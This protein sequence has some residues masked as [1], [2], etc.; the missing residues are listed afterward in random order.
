MRPAIGPRTR[1]RNCS[2]RQPLGRDQQDVNLIASDRGFDGVPLRPVLRMDGRRSHAHA[3]GRDDLVAHQRQQ[4]RDQQ[5][6]SQA[7]LPEQL[8]R[9]EIDRALAPARLLH[10]EQ[11]PT[12]L[13]HMADGVLL[14]LAKDGGCVLRAQPQEF[15]CAGR[16]VMHGT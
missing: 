9:D 11:S 5:R 15:E 8:G 6:R 16:A 4:G 7:L 13:H 2:L 3:P 14:A 12:P 10:D 1:L